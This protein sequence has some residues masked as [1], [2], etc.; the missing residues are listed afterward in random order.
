MKSFQQFLYEKLVQQSASRGSNDGGVYK[1]TDDNSEHYIKHPFNPDQAKSEVLSGKIHN[2]M[3]VHTLNPKISHVESNRLSVSTKF[4]HNLEP[5]KSKHLPSLTSEH[6]K[7]LGKIY[8]AGVLTKNWDALGTGIEHGQ[9]NVAIDKKRGHFVSLDQGGS[10]NFRASGKYKDYKN[11]ISEKDS[12]RDPKIS[13]GAHIINHAMSNPE[14]KPHVLHTLKR[15]DMGKVHEAFKNSG[16]HN[17]E[18]LH[19]NF[20][21]RHQKLID[22]L[23]H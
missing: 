4:N 19:K 9:G 13:A 20:T 2:L 17:W 21:E 1:E 7:Q 5:L 10:F 8:A 3:G 12:L 23:S 11:D 15:M 22:H 6:H 18:E 14:V 16:L